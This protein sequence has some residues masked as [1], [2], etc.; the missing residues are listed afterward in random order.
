MADTK[1]QILQ[2]AFGL[3]LKKSY[4][5]VSLNEIVE[6]AGLTKGAFY[7]YYRSKEELFEAVVKYFYNH[8][9]ITDFRNFPRTSLKEFYST[10]LKLLEDPSNTGDLEEGDTNL[11]LFLHEASRRVNDFLSIHIAQRKKEIWA[12]T[13]IIET[14]KRKKEIKSDIP[15]EQIANMF[16]NLSDGISMNR[17]FINKDGITSLKELQRDWDNLY[18]LLTGK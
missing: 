10:Y 14:A 16:I 15:D 11:F 7:H 17:A 9:L 12:W 1:K 8:G 4:K 13:E 5:E 3:F 2:I 6:E 18:R